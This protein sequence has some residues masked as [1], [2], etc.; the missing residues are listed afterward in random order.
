MQSQTHN[1]ESTT[2]QHNKLTVPQESTIQSTAVHIN[3]HILVFHPYRVTQMLA[4]V[5]FRSGEIGKLRER[6]KQMCE[7]G[8]LLAFLTRFISANVC[9][10]IFSFLLYESLT[11][12][13]RNLIRQRDS[14]SQIYS[15][16]I[17][18][19][20]PSSRVITDRFLSTQM[21]SI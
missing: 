12:P 10:V 4:A 5:F 19:E 16:M 14:L 6:E 17:C 20:M 11:M 18:E 15:E 2:V 13:Y 7:L 21:S 1:I 8:F 3:H 9:F